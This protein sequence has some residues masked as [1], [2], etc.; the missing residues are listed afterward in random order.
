MD[1]FERLNSHVLAL[2]SVRRRGN[3]KRAFRIRV[4]KIRREL[5]YVVIIMYGSDLK[6]S[7]NNFTRLLFYL[8][9]TFPLCLKVLAFMQVL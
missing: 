3:E 1:P 6:F 9:L 4:E 7:T 8:N 2:T 5:A